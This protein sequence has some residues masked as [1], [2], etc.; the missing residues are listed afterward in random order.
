MQRGRDGRLTAERRAAWRDLT[1]FSPSR[2]TPDRLSAAFR[3]L[4]GALI[5]NAMSKGIFFATIQSGHQ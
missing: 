4:A 2:M 1:W 3:G 5:L